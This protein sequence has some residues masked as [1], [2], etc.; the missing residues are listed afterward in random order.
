MIFK[1]KDTFK[2]LFIV[3]KET[4]EGFI[5][6]FKDNNPLHTNQQFAIPNYLSSRRVNLRVKFDF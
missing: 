1:V 2:E 6:V 4:Y 3:N 5:H